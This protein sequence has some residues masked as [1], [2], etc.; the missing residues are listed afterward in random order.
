MMQRRSVILLVS[1]A[2]T[3]TIYYWIRGASFFDPDFGIHMRMGQLIISEGIIIRDTM[4]YSMPSYPVVDHEWLTDII[5][6]RL[7]PVVGYIGL[8]GIFAFVALGALLLQLLTVRR[9]ER[10]LAVIPLFLTMAILAVFAGV[11]PQVITWFFFSLI[12]F[13]VRDPE[14]FWKWRLVLPGVFLIWANLH[15]GF[16]VGLAVLLAACVYWGFKKRLIFGMSALF[17]FSAGATLITPYWWRTW[18]EIAMSMSENSLR[19]NI[20][21][22]APTVFVLYFSFWIFLVLS[23][24]LIIRHRKRF[25]FLDKLL[26][27][28]LLAMGLSAVRHFPLWALA[29]FPM[30]TRGLAFLYREAS[31][32]KYGRSRFEKSLKVLFVILIILLSPD[33]LSIYGA[34]GFQNNYPEKAIVYLRTHKP[35][36]EIFS[37]YDWGGY[38]NWKLPEKK[39]FINGRM[40]H[41]RQEVYSTS[42]SEDAF[43]EYIRLLGGELSLRE[44]ATKYRISTLLVPVEKKEAKNVIAEEIARFDRWVKSGLRIPK[45]KDASIFKV[46]DEAKKEGWEVVYKDDAFVIYQDRDYE[47]EL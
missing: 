20:S 27:F 41:W 17:V 43:D 9:Q 8:A 40:P 38:L 33:L 16:P 31:G 28:G 3:A 11:R 37:L 10:R 35:K 34:I 15:G 21:E 23:A 18:W 12:L 4:S 6:V 44:V 2:A 14:R 46:S 1:L 45:E 26:Y 39:V 24:F 32:I 22:W 29:A 5:L 7:L 36:G 13:I 19:W 30:A 25:T 47:A 42:E